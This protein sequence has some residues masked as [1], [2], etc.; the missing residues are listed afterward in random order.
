M[1]V[2]YIS[3]FIAP[4]PKNQQEEINVSDKIVV[5][6]NLD[7]SDSNEIASN[8]IGFY[9]DFIAI[10]NANTFHFFRTN[11]VVIIFQAQ[12]FCISDKTPAFHFS[13]P[14]PVFS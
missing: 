7:S 2:A 9:T 8:C 13:R 11:N 14:P 4:T 5:V 1:V 3:C 10:N 12:Y 6:N